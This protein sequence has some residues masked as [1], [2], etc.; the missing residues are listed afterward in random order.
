MRSRQLAVANVRTRRQPAGCHP[1]C[2]RVAW[3]R[4]CWLL[5]SRAGGRGDVPARV[6]FGSS[7]GTGWRP[8]G[9]SSVET[10]LR[11]VPPR[12][13]PIRRMGGGC[14]VRTKYA[15]HLHPSSGWVVWTILSSLGENGFFGILREKL[16]DGARMRR[17]REVTAPRPP[18]PCHPLGPHTINHYGGSPLFPSDVASW[19]PV[20]GMTS[21]AI[22]RP[23]WAGAP[24]RLR[25]CFGGQPLI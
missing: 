20:A 17:Q 18:S 14:D 2:A 8:P 19:R 5:R 13:V 25:A 9:L 22:E 3:M 4:R 12:R 24:R 10:H 6:V 11:W 15:S 7:G 23:G 21:N 16:G 1:T